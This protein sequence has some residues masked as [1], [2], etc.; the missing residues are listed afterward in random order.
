V[1]LDVSSPGAASATRTPM[2]TRFVAGLAVAVGL[3]AGVVVFGRIASTERLAM[4]LTALWFGLMAGACFLAWRRRRD[5][6][7]PLGVGYGVVALAAGVWLGLPQI[8]DRTVDE[9]VVTGAPSGEAGSG[10]VRVAQGGF[11]SVA[12]QTGGSA[13]VVRLANGE[14][15]LTLT[16]FRTD[17]GPDLRVYLVPRA[18]ATRWTAPSTSAR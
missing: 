11:R 2:A 9:R 15:R 13:S 3:A 6:L 16:G 18:A 7:V 12:H 5:L 10:N 8:T 4:A 17:N 1:N 14:H